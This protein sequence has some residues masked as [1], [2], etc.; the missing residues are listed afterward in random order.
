MLGTPHEY[1]AELRTDVNREEKS[2]TVQP[3][4]LSGLGGRRGRDSRVP[5]CAKEHP[6]QLG[7]DVVVDDGHDAGIHTWKRLR[8]ICPCAKCSG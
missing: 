2:V 6:A 4:R 5:E 1:Q 3:D 8:A 7:A